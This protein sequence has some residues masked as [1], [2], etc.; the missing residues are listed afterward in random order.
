LASLYFDADVSVRIAAV[1]ED[2][3]HSVSTARDLQLRSASDATQFLTAAELGAILIMANRK[4]FVLLHDAW[5][6]WSVAW[7]VIRPHP[8]V[9]VVEVWPDDRSAD[10]I[11]DLVGGDHSF[12]NELWRWRNN[13]WSLQVVA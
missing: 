8:G 13:R 1:L 10:E 5:T 12:V 6:R 2:R 9:I 11:E 7:G 3:G 4:D